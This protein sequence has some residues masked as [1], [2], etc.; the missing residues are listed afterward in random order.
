MGNSYGNNVI[1]L[2]N[3]KFNADPANKQSY[4][5]SGTNMYDTI[6]QGTSALGTITSATFNP[7]EAGFLR[8]EGSGYVTWDNGIDLPE[9]TN[10]ITTDAWF[11]SSDAADRGIFCFE[12][13]S[14]NII[15]QLMRTS[16]VGQLLYRWYNDSL[17]EA[18]VNSVISEEGEWFNIVVV[19]EGTNVNIYKNGSL[20]SAQS[21]FEATFD[22][23]NPGKFFIGT[24]NGSDRFWNGDISCV[25]VYSKAFS[26]SEV[27]QNYNAL[28]HRFINIGS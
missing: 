10:A 21:G 3:L 12:N 6:F 16:N 5:G 9:G 28:K 26:A 23:S 4:P 14:G 27:F 1:V 8:Y 25:K 11:N 15:F 17:H 7:L 2:D 19:H 18:T 20:F 13:S 22:L 24:Q